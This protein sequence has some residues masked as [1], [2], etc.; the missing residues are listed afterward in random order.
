MC[1]QHSCVFIHT[2]IFSVYGYGDRSGTLVDLCVKGFNGAS[3]I[4]LGPCTQKWNYL[5]ID[6]FCEI[7]LRL[8]MNVES[9]QVINVA[10]SDTRC[11]REYIDDIYEL[12]NKSG[13]CEYGQVA[14]NPEGSPQLIPDIQRML[15]YSE[16]KAFKDFKS[17]IREVMEKEGLI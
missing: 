16:M 4:K 2:R 17:G 13:T 3:E 5:Y 7:I 9:T 10:G 6:D 14:S 8:L 15:H 11:L 12:S 1:A